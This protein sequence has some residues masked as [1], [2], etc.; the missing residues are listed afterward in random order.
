MSNLVWLEG[1]NSKWYLDHF[2]T[3][4]RIL[5]CKILKF[6][7][8][9]SLNYY[10]NFLRASNGKNLIFRLLDCLDWTRYRSWKWFCSF[11]IYICSIYIY[12][13]F[14]DFYFNLFNKELSNFCLFLKGI[15]FREINNRH[16]KMNGRSN[17][18]T[19][20]IKL[21]F[22]NFLIIHKVCSIDLSRN[23]SKIWWYIEVFFE[24]I[25][26]HFA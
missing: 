20:H 10:I 18:G 6:N 12:T 14:C 22:V 26:N 15:D 17:F 2:W 11:G 3:S 8:F 1:W 7:I 19:K 23:S 9:L 16:P 5:N 25:L 4:P 13:L 24:I 21:K